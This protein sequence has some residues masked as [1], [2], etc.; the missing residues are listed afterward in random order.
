MTR[1][2]LAALVIALSMALVPSRAA[3]EINVADSLE[4]MVADAELVVRGAVIAIQKQPGEGQVM[5]YRVTL[6][7]SETL[8]GKRSRTI[9]FVIRHLHGETPEVWRQ[10]KTELLLFLISSKRRVG[11]DPGYGLEPFALRERDAVVRLRTHGSDPVYT[12]D[13]VKLTGRTEILKAARQAVAAGAS[14]SKSH[15]LDVPVSSPAYGALWAGSAVWLVAP[16]G[17]K[18][19]KLG[20]QWTAS[21]DVSQ[22]EEG[23]K[24]LAHFR[25]AAN[26]ALLRKLLADPGFVEISASQRPRVRRFIVRAAAHQTLISWGVSV[27]QPVLDRPAP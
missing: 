23:V 24:A 17:A 11:D 5:W 7:V 12:L 20:Q 9:R 25:S 19:E 13:F 4:W 14:A 26:V 6:R 18:L 21:S 22:R 27:K 15:N 10:K 2:L 8:E 16:I 1:R 3:A